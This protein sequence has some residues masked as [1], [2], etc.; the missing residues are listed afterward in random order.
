MDADC[1][2]NA[3]NS[4]L[5]MGGGVCGAIFRAAGARDLQAACD[6][7]GYCPTGSAVITSGFNLK[8]RY[9][10]HAVGPIWQGG[11]N[12]EPEHLRG[13]YSAALDRASEND[14]HTIGFPLISSGIFGYPKDK[15]WREALSSCNDW[16]TAHQDYDIDITFAVLSD[17][18]LELGSK[19]M[20]DIGIS[21]DEEDDGFVFF[22]KLGHPG[23]EFSNWYPRQFVLEGIKYN[24]VEQYMMAKK[25]LLFGDLDI[26]HKIM[27]S[28]DPGECKDLGKKVSNFDP[29]AWDSCKYEIVYNANHAK[30]SQNPDL[31][32]KLLSTGDAIMA[33]ASPYDKIWGIGMDQYDPGARTPEHWNGQNLLGNILMQIR[34]ESENDRISWFRKYIPVLTMID[35]DEELKRACREYSAYAP[36]DGTHSSVTLYLYRE[37][38]Q[39]AYDSNIV[40]HN[41]SEITDECGTK[42]EIARPTQ[43]FLESLS[44]EQILAC[45]AWH[46][47]RDH[48][49]EGSLVRHSI[50]EGYMLLM[51]TTYM[52]K[53]DNGSAC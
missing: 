34:S 50:G 49:V 52:N 2:V 5:A 31:M 21:A 10:I 6:K 9:V 32:Q 13:C 47:R 43:M 24:C 8:A 36:A 23:E 16:I 53:L 20:A 29:D 25:A 3:A 7:I 37:F 46:F 51:M 27:A 39:E 1:I 4:H 42:E 26:Y 44:A 12:H 11:N 15:A 17:D 38:M 22:W 18:I 19:I 33:E 28:S 41:Y 45:I 48:F 30:F 40:I 35:N 14:C